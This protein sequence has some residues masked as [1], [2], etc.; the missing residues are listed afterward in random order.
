MLA[1]LSWGIR[2]KQLKQWQESEESQDP[3][4]VPPAAELGAFLST[5]G[6]PANQFMNLINADMTSILPK[7]NGKLMCFVGGLHTIMKFGNACGELFGN[8]LETYFGAW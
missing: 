8:M 6:Q 2:D 4:S 1:N 5:D 7:Y 3:E